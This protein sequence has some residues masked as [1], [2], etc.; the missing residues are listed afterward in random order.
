LISKSSSRSYTV[1]T[2]SA[3]SAGQLP[4]RSSSVDDAGSFAIDGDSLSIPLGKISKRQS[5]NPGLRLAQSI[6][7]RAPSDLS[8][9][10]SPLLEELHST[11][12]PASAVPSPALISTGSLGAHAQAS[13]IPSNIPQEITNG[14]VT[15]QYGQSH[16]FLCRS[17]LLNVVQ[18]PSAL[19]PIRRP[20]T[21]DLAPI[22]LFQVMWTR[23]V[24]RPMTATRKGFLQLCLF[25][26]SLS[27]GQRIMGK[28]KADLNLSNFHSMMIRP[29]L[30]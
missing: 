5:L 26:L 15:D 30:I 18:A 3:D 12:D 10:H 8:L 4:T 22:R 17:I 27:M 9:Q 29:S 7:N 2:L 23:M 14:F 11:P 20:T 16:Q 1:P 24:A 19:L 13:S 21:N 28:V 25:Q 6:E